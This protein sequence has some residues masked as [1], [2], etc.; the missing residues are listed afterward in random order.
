MGESARKFAPSPCR[1][2]RCGHKFE[3]VTVVVAFVAVGAL[4]LLCEIEN[5]NKSRVE[6]TKLAH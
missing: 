5:P 3:L 1:S 4:L 2:V 6:P